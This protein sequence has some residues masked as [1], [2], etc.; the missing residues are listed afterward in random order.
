ML[1]QVEGLTIGD[2]EIARIAAEW[3][4]ILAVIVIG[5]AVVVSMLSGLIVRFRSDGPAYIQNAAGSGGSTA[6]E[7]EKLAGLHQRGALTDEEFQAEKS[8]LLS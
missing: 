6:D 1:D 3:I 4:E 8:K 2:F 7:L 5:V